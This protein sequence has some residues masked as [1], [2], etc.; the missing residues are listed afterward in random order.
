[1]SRAREAWGAVACSPPT[2]VATATSPSGGVSLS[3]I[4]EEG[5]DGQGQRWE[6]CGGQQGERRLRTG[7]RVAEG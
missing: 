3:L 6:G 2:L 5:L 1:M 7:Y 4:P